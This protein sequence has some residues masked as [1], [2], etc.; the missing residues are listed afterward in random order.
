MPGDERFPSLRRLT[1]DVTGAMHAQE[2]RSARR[3]RVIRNMTAVAAVVGVLGVPAALGVQSLL[4]PD[5]TADLPEHPV[6][7]GLERQETGPPV[8]IA[9]GNI[10][11]LAWGL[12][13]RPCEYE[14]VTTIATALILS[15]GAA[16]ANP[17]PYV[18]PGHAPHRMPILRPEFSF[19]GENRRTFVTGVVPA[20]VAS[21]DL[22]LERYAPTPRRPGREDRRVVGV[23]TK[24]FLPGARREGRLPGGLRA[25]V[26]VTRGQFVYTRAIARTAGGRVLLDCTRR[27]CDR[28]ARQR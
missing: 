3:R 7:A 10:G 21:V 19:F 6:P 14:D 27:E 8:Y 22:H 4:A 23:A 26:Y 9:R 12:T 17:C 18:D 28:L 16:G 13:A 11:S 24:P 20:R 15:D 25:F 5:P 1:A 2:R